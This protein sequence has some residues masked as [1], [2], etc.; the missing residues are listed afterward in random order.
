[1][2]RI[3]SGM[4][5]T[6]RLHLGHYHGVL[7]NWVKLQN[8]FDCF[9]FSADWHA[10]TT[11]YRASQNIR[12]DTADMVLDW[13][14]VGIDPAKAVL[15]R[16]SDV[17]QH[18]ELFTLFSMITP[19]PWLERVPT[20]KEQQENLTEK[21]L[22]TLGFL[23]YPVLQSADIAIYRAQVVPVGEDQL[24][25]L[26]LTREIVRRFNHFYGKTFPEPDAMLTETPRLPGVDGR[27]MSK[28]YGNAIMLSDTPAEATKKVMAYVTDPARK[29]RKDP[30]NPDVC[31]LYNQHKLYS[32]EE[33]K[34]RVQ[35]ECRNAAIGCVDCKKL[36]LA[37]VL[38]HHAPM[39]EKRAALEKDTDVAAL[40]E[41][42]AKKATDVAEKTM[43]DVRKAIGV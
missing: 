39:F 17:K 25:H 8:E 30:G 14:A 35:V 38:E 4:R 26:E 15:F 28:S 12:Q 10:L 29:L 37:N 1:M 13:L 42:G 27:K 19:V 11:E 24:P 23:A 31:T 32:P 7:K 5:P 43:T 40:L 34:A 18:A 21:D 9:F 16:Q 20:Y 36:A 6:G 2:K 41:A 33:T 22:N 3:L